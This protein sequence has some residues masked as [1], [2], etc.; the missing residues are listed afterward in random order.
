MEVERQFAFLP[1]G[2]R[3]AETD[4]N[5]NVVPLCVKNGHSSVQSSMQKI[6]GHTPIEALVVMQDASRPLGC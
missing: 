6:R 5:V 2:S 1:E 4:L 3:K